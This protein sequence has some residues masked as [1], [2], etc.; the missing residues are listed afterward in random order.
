MLGSL[1]GAR[2]LIESQAFQAAR[3]TDTSHLPSPT[4]KNPR[5]RREAAPST[6]NRCRV[7]MC[8][9]LFLSFS[10]FFSPPLPVRLFFPPFWSSLLPRWKT[11]RLSKGSDSKLLLAPSWNMNK[12]F[13][14]FFFFRNED[15]LQSISY[16]MCIYIY[17]KYLQIKKTKFY[18]VAS[19]FPLNGSG[20]LY[21]C[22]KRKFL[23]WK[24][25]EWKFFEVLILWKMSE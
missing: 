25:Y 11:T 13:F 22:S 18:G 16:F 21:F 12:F 1:F 5:A 8:T 20:F 7:A 19:R 2:T 14:F 10:F 24:F 4:G 3:I 6:T 15:F 9:A 17:C 23:K